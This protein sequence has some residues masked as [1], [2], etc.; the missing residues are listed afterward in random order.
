MKAM[1]LRKVS[2]IEAAPLELQ[3]WPLPQVGPRQILV[4]VSTCGVCHTEIDEIEG[5]RQP[6]LPVILGHE[7]VGGVVSGQ[8]HWP[9][10]NSS[11]SSG[12]PVDLAALCVRDMT[13][14]PLVALVCLDRFVSVGTT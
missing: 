12:G 1:V 4:K 2:Q 9:L 3:N 14:S 8:G 10:V 13:V 7:I 5:R 6:K 11:P